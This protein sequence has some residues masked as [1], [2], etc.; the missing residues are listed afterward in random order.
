M[1]VKF[2]MVDKYYKYPEG[3]KEKEFLDGI[4]YSANPDCGTVKF[5]LD[6]FQLGKTLEDLIFELGSIFGED[7]LIK[8][9]GSDLKLVVFNGYL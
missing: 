5:D 8:F 2:G 1:I 3:S 7:L 9:E 4:S 6:A